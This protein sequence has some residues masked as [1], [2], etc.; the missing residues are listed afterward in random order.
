MLDALRLSLLVLE[1][2]LLLAELVARLFLF[3]LV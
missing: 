2:L 1:K 3:G